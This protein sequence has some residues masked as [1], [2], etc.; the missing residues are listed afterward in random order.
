MTKWISISG[1]TFLSFYIAGLIYLIIN[2]HRLKKCVLS[3]EKS[4]VYKFFT[5][6]ILVIITRILSFSFVITIYL[7]DNLSND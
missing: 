2:L 4:N 3:K 1:L 5:I 7:D 6:E